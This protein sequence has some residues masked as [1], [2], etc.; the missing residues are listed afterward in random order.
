MKRVNVLLRID[1]LDYRL[2]VKVLWK[3]KLNKDSVDIVLFVEP[4]NQLEQFLLSCLGRKRV[5]LR[6]K[7][8]NLASLFLVVY[9][10]P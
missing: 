6:L 8:Y 3:R 4:V 5:L 7:A 2:V 10:N 9:V 1:C